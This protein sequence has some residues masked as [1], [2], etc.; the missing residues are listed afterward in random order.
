MQKINAS[1]GEIVAEE[2]FDNSTR[3]LRMQLTKI[4]SS[5]PDAVFLSAGKII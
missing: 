3:D 4:K 5:Q 1:D 2:L